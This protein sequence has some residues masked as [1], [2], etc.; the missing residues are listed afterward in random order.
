M[1]NQ[2]AF[3][4]QPGID[5]MF[6]NSRVVLFGNAIIAFGAYRDGGNTALALQ[7]GVGYQF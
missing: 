5:Y 4:L 7:T 1:G 6:P 3:V 2:T